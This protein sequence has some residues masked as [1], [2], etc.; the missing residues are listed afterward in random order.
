MTRSGVDAL[1]AR[2]TRALIALIA[3]IL[4]ILPSHA[5]NLSKEDADRVKQAIESNWAHPADLLESPRRALVRAAPY[6]LPEKEYHKWKVM[7]LTFHISAL[8]H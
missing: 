1:C 3:L 8:E 2:V 6:H 5:E 4:I 7:T